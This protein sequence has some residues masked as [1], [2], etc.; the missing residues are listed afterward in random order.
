MDHTDLVVVRSFPSRIE[1]DVAQGALE[2]DGIDALVVAD[3][4]G[5]Q[6]SSLWVSGVQL[7]VRN[8]DAARASEVLDAQI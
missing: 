8:E 5:G 4:A 2:A 7:L 3:D 1:A 6:Y